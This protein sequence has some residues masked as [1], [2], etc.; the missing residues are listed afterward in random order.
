MDF[1]SI[2]IPYAKSKSLFVNDLIV[3]VYEPKKPPE[4]INYMSTSECKQV[5]PFV[6]GA[7]IDLWETYLRQNTT[8]VIMFSDGGPH[9]FKI[10]KTINL[11]HWLVV[12]YNINIEY[13]FF[14]SYHG[15]S[16]C[17]AHAGHVKSAI[18]KL[19]QPGKVYTTL[20]AVLKGL[21]A[22]NLKNATFDKLIMLEETIILELKK[23]P[24]L[25]IYYK[26]SYDGREIK[27]YKLSRDDVAVKS[28]AF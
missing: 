19:I 2:A 23:S 8:K 12:M 14:E 26:F 16:L 15:S 1:T 21:K 10:W 17:D 6:E 7:L 27:I 5:Y 22:L 24:P 25:R 4:W 9:H 18:R 20:N 3:T 13:H 28:I 11:F